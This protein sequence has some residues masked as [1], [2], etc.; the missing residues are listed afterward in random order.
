MV[1]K[2][3]TDGKIFVTNL[4]YTLIAETE[5]SNCDSNN[6]GSVTGDTKE[7]SKADFDRLL[8]NRWETHMSQGHF[9]YGLDVLET[10]KVI[11]DGMYLFFCGIYIYIYIYI[12]LSRGCVRYVIM[13]L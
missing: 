13:Y 2:V 10:R 9:R 4:D 11:H 12:I 7:G 1:I 5:G 3:L 8:R 6:S